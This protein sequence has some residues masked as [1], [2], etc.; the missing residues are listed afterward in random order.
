MQSQDEKNGQN[1]EEHRLAGPDGTQTLSTGGWPERLGAARRDGLEDAAQ[2]P[3]GPT[4][5]TRSHAPRLLV[6]RS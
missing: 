1:L 3:D 5:A 6:T 4:R 2:A